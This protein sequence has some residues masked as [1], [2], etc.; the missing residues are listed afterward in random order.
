MLISF[1]NNN[2]NNDISNAPP[3]MMTNNNNNSNREEHLRCTRLI[4][5]CERSNRIVSDQ[6]VQKMKKFKKMQGLK[7]KVHGITK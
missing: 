7:I 4:K 5:N 6:Q 2:N 3:L 1:N